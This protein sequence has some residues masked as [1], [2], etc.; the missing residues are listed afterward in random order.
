MGYVAGGLLV[1][2]AADV[3]SFEGAIALVAGLTAV[4]GLWVWLE[5]PREELPAPVTGEGLP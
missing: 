2:V 5:L 4:S 1:G 3:A